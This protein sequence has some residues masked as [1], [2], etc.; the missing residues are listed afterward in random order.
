VH[1]FG[2]AN[3]GI[4]RTSF[5]AAVTPGTIG[6]IDKS[7]TFF[8]SFN[9]HRHPEHLGNIGRRGS[10]T[11]RTTI[12]AEFP[13]NDFFSRLTAPSFTTLTTLSSRKHRRNLIN[14]RITIDL[15]NHPGIA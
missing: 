4:E 7:N 9:I 1:L 12:R 15:K 2:C 10:S 6:F 3:N 5:I 13:L 14:H 8:L 11:R